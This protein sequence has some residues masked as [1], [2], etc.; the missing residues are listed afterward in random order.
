[1]APIKGLARAGVFGN[2]N[3]VFKNFEIFVLFKI[4]FLNVFNGFMLKIIIFY[5]NI[6]LNEKYFKLYHYYNFV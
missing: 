5:F 2:A 3:L 6:F 4:I 1:M